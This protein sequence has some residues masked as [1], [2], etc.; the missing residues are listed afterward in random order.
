M[1]AAARR[2][3]R[4]FGCNRRREDERRRIVAGKPCADKPSMNAAQKAP[5]KARLARTELGEPGTTVHHQHAFS[6]SDNWT[7]DLSMTTAGVWLA[8]FTHGCLSD[9]RLATC[10]SRRHSKKSTERP[11]R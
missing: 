9:R 2:T 6:S 10:N 7:T 11:D 3:A 4:R 5:D 8:I 1:G